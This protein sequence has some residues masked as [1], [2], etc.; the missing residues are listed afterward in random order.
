M[1]NWCTVQC[2][3]KI[4]FQDWFTQWRVSFFWVSA[5]H[6]FA[7]TKVTTQAARRINHL[8]LRAKWLWLIDNKLPGDF[9][10][11]SITPLIQPLEFF[12][13]NYIWFLEVVVGWEWRGESGYQCQG[14]SQLELQWGL[15][16]PGKPGGSN[17]ASHCT[18]SV[19]RNQ[20][21]LQGTSMYTSVKTC[22]FMTWTFFFFSSLALSFFLLLSIPLL[23]TYYCQSHALQCLQLSPTQLCMSFQSSGATSLLSEF[24]FV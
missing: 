21:L 10:P 6:G 4:I 15:N 2:R 20:H 24:T 8:S 3:N 17:P 12:S 23:P 22:C 19:V 9:Y 13:E 5:P 14:L 1:Q 11:W 16:W 7:A 18:E